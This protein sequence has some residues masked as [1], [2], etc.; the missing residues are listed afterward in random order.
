MIVLAYVAP[1]LR[2][3]GDAV[4]AA[5]QVI[6]ANDVINLDSRI[7]LTEGA[8]T[9]FTPTYTNLTVGNGVSV[10][11]YKQVGNIVFCRVSFTLGTTSSMGTDP[12]F[13]LPVAPKAVTGNTLFPFPML[14]LDAGATY[15]YGF[16]R[17][18]YGSPSQATLFTLSTTGT[19]SSYVGI[20]ATVPMTWTTGDSFATTLVY[21]A[22]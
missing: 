15:Y 19:Y 16:I 17:L 3:V 18:Y 12:Y 1:T 11:A 13:S 14:I 9:S 6:I 8:W 22:A 5:D 4:T 10:A 21:E 20:T 7:A 2:S